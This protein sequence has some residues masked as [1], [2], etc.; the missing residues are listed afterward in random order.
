MNLFSKVDIEAAAKA[1]WENYIERCGLPT[2]PPLP[3]AEFVGWWN[4]E[5][6][7]CISDFTAGVT[8]AMASVQ[9]R[10]AMTEVQDQVC[11]DGAIVGWHP[12]VI[13]RLQED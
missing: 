3:D 10:G 8:A 4:A 5:R 1:M 6:P 12:A 2:D 9:A 11:K 7:Q 13:I